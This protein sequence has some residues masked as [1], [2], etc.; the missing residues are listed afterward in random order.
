MSVMNTKVS[1][2][3]WTLL[4]GKCSKILRASCL[5]K[6][7]LDKQHRL[8]LDCFQRSSLIRVFP[9][10]YSDKHLVNSSP[11]NPTFYLRT[12][13]KSVQILNIYHFTDSKNSTL[14]RRDSDKRL[15]ALEK[16]LQAASASIIATQPWQQKESKSEEIRRFETRSYETKQ[17]QF[18][19][20]AVSRQEM[21][22][23]HGYPRSMSP[24]W[25][26]I[27]MHVSCLTSFVF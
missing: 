21:N 23:H 19:Q 11:E 13:E 2:F 6:K 10:C 20:E 15:E 1:Q 24:V 16:S 27:P 18:H 14:D 8:R 17:E 22:G 5:P 12:E 9:V 3:T 4:Y 26:N 7:G 25:D